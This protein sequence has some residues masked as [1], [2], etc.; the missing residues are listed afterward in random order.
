MDK[1]IGRKKELDL[2]NQLRDKKSSTF[3][4]VYGR[5]RVGKTF[6]IRQ[7]F[8]NKFDFY[9]TG[10]SNVNLSQ[11][12]SNFHAAL[13]K[14]DPSAYGKKPAA[15][16][17]TAFQQL[18]VLLE[19]SKRKK[20]I[21]FLDELPWLDTAQSDFVPALEHFW[22]SWASMRNDVVLIAC[23]SAAG[24]MIN[25]LINNKGGLHNRVTHRIRLEP[26]T[27]KE[28]EY[29][30]KYKKAIFDRYQI[31]QLYM[32]MGGIPFYLEQ[33]DVRQSAAQN[34]NRLCFEKDGILR[35]EF[36]NLYQSL[37]DNADKHIAVIEALS[38]KAK[39]LTRGELI[40]G[41]KLATG[42][43][44][45]RILKELE[46]SG[47]IRKYISYGKKERNSLYQLTDFYSLFY[48]KFIR[49]AGIL[50]ENA[51]INGLDSPEQRAWSSYAFEQVCLTHI[52]EIKKALGISGVQTTTS[53]WI[54]TA[55]A[56]IDL[57]IDRRD[58]VI[59]ICEMKF[60]INNFTID[61]KYAEEL[62]N[63]VGIFRQETKTRK[64]I[65]LTMITTFELNKNNYSNSLVQNS[66]KMDV[67]F[68]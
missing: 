35:S 30:L 65:F 24:W 55:G 66:L 32:V 50:D 58:Q 20:K 25:K 63:K 33:I 15:D 46:E 8:D 27:L 19:S 28:C 45:T 29:F 68:D 36:D 53:S 41:A 6:L 42:G 59:N 13:T 10:M 67:L 18:S 60:S 17:F 48:L 4:A 34:I 37:F 31:I 52:G 3:V 49:K 57:V 7:A 56:Q 64:A 9:L 51:W 21:I 22:N 54:S 38:K 11:Q 40:K 44:V 39:G 47:F 1:L 23:G 61:K 43:S 2:L 26:F 14:Y 62:R 16:W 5:R 12:L